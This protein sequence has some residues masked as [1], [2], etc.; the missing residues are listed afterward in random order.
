VEQNIPQITE[1]ADKLYVL[2]E[3]SISF[4]GSKEDALCNDHLKE[5]FLGM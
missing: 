5:I 2:E 4:E 1:L 3:G